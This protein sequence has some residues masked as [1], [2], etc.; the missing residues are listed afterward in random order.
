LWPESEVIIGGG[1]KTT[2]RR[3]SQPDVI[4]ITRRFYRP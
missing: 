3:L 4:R 1:L 2:Q